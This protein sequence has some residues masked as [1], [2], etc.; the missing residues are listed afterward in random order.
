MILFID[1]EKRRTGSYRDELEFLDFQVVFKNS[2]DEAI[3]FLEENLPEVEL[4]ILDIMMPSKEIFKEVDTSDGLRTGIFVFEWIRRKSRS[5]PTIILTN[6]NDEEVK[7]R[8]LGE[9]H[10]WFARKPHYKPYELGELVVKT[11]GGS[12]PTVD[13]LS[14]V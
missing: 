11:L 2:V 9:G 3:H 7:Q 4:V 10:C 6:L 8:F 12:I 1:D 14:D 13:N 5:L